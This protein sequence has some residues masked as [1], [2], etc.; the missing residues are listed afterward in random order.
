MDVDEVDRFFI[1]NPPGPG[2]WA[3]GV[4]G[5]PERFIDNPEEVGRG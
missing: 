2:L 5:R 4:A 3:A 1:L